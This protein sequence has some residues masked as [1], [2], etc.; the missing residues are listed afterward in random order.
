MQFFVLRSK[1][2]VSAGQLIQLT[3]SMVN[4]RSGRHFFVRFVLLTYA[5]AFKY[6][7]KLLGGVMIALLL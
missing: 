2:G 3:P 6:V 4:G 5:S 1:N 7:C